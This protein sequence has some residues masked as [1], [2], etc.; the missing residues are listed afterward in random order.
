MEGRA[1]TPAERYAAIGGVI[2]FASLF[3]HWYG[4]DTVVKGVGVEIAETGWSA[5][6]FLR[7]LVALVA[8][9]AVALPAARL[10]GREVHLPFAP[11]AVL[12]PAGGLTA[13]LI[14][15][16]IVSPPGKADSIE[17]GIFVSLVGAILIAVG[18]YQTLQEQG[19]SLPA[20][21]GALVRGEHRGNAVR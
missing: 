12:A 3:M 11:G 8:I 16:R 21:L 9:A 14:L 2:L 5:T 10:L 19:T 4:Y 17:F 20:E 1:P 15:W 18:S 7:F 6:D 13:L